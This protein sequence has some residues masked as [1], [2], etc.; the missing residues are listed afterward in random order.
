MTKKFNLF[1][2]S[3]IMLICLGIQLNAMQSLTNELVPFDTSRIYHVMDKARNG[4]EIT[5]GFI[6]GSITKGYAASSDSKR[7]INLVTDWW[8]TTFPKAKINMINAGIGGTGSNIGAFRVKEDLLSH[9][10]DFVIVEFAVNDSLNDFSMQTMEG[11]VRQILQDLGNPGLMMLCLREAK[12]RTAQKYHIPVAKHYKI[13]LVSFADLID[14]QVAKDGV[15][16]NSIFSDGLHPLDSGM[17]Y[18]ADF[19]TDELNRIYKTLPGEKNLP[20]INNHIPRPITTN[21]FENTTKYN[22]FNLQPRSN[23]G[24]KNNENGWYA[25]TPG[26]EMIFQLQGSFIAVLYSRYKTENRGKVEIWLDNGKHTIL[27]AYWTESWGPATI[28]EVLGEN[29]NDAIHNLHIKIVDEHDNGTNGHYF[30][31]LNVLSAKKSKP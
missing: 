7:W 19:I 16:I 11:L 14:K 30:Q 29:L 21:L 17:K 28:F 9:H 5:L 22:A 18:I 8:K 15:P 10:P 6:G 24:W 13:P 26:S 1:L 2:M 20:P 27:N 4:K 23:D 3:A 25:D 12:G 31:L